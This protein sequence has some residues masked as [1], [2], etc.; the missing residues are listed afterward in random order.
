MI[1]SFDG[2]VTPSDA[3]T[4]VAS[5]RNGRSRIVGEVDLKV[6]R[7]S[8]Y[9]VRTPE[10]A[11]AV[12]RGNPPGKRVECSGRL[13]E[14][15]HGPEDWPPSATSTGQIEEIWY[16]ETGEDDEPGTSRRIYNTSKRP[17]RSGGWAFRFVVSIQRPEMTAP[18]PLP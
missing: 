13:R 2:E 15:R 8:G 7:F 17:P 3:M 11:F 9:L 6:G 12:T 14:K 18:P 16:C 10:A 4:V 1:V 5:D